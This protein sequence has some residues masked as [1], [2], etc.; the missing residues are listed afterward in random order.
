MRLIAA[1]TALAGYDVLVKAHIHH[2]SHLPFTPPE[3]SQ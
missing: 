3:T 2:V 1:A